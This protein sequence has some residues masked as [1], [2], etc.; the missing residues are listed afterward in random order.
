MARRS[1][2]RPSDPT[3][4]EDCG[5]VAIRN[6]GAKSGL[7]VVDGKRQVIYA[8]ANVPLRERYVL[9]AARASHAAMQ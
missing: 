4:L 5:Y 1:P 7:W 2:K 9:A 3:R 8:K 6:N